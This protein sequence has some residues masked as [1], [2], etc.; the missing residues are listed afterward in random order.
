MQNIMN[1]KR[2][3]EGLCSYAVISKMKYK[4]K[5]GLR[6]DDPLPSLSMRALGERVPRFLATKIAHLHDLGPV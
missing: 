1:E 5:V 6:R 3:K 4:S 2:R